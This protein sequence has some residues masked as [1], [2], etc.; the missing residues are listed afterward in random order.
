MPVSVGKLAVSAL[1]I[2][3]RDLVKTSAMKFILG[4]NFEAAV[5]TGAGVGLSR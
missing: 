1:N 4:W 3:S 5:M 2:D